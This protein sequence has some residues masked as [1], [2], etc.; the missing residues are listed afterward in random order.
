[1]INI[2]FCSL[3]LKYKKQPSYHKSWP[4]FML[5]SQSQGTYRMVYLGK[6]NLDRKKTMQKIALLYLYANLG[7][8]GLY[9]VSDWC[10]ISMVIEQDFIPVKQRF[11]HVARTQ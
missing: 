5:L 1:M 11:L 10:L 4:L 2:W 9:L 7:Y 3:I 8:L 6:L